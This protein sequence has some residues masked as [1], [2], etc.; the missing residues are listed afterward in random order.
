MNGGGRNTHP[1]RLIIVSSTGLHFIMIKV[2]ALL[3]LRVTLNIMNTLKICLIKSARTGILPEE[4]LT[5]W[6]N[7]GIEH[8]EEQQG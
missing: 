1:Y 2:E 6:I 5:H 4:D 3:Y 8:A 7:L